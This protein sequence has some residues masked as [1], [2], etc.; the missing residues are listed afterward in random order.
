[1]EVR[2]EVSEMIILQG[3][4]K[5]RKNHQDQIARPKEGFILFLFEL[6]EGAK[7]R[8]EIGILQRWRLTRRMDKKKKTYS[9]SLGVVSC[10]FK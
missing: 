4:K 8:V 2:E 1:M 3:R 10:V 9:L 6:I 5:S 7:S